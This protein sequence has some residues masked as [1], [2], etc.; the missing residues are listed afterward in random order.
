MNPNQI[1]NLLEKFEDKYKK[2]A[3]AASQKQYVYHLKPEKLIGTNLLSLGE[4]ENKHPEIYKKEVKKYSGRENHLTKKI[5]PL[6]CTWKDCIIFSSVN[7]QMIFDLQGLLGIKGWKE[8]EDIS[9][10]RFDINDLPSTM[11]L[12]DDDAE[13]YKKISPKSYRES[14]F[15][16]VSTARHFAECAEDNVYPLLFAGVKHVLVNEPIR[17]SLADT[18]HYK[19]RGK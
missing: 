3:E 6:G 14:E 4:L 5:E 16:P 13:S 10:M 15:I 7:P 12:Y 19:S 9:Y 8:A 2:L 18:F 1:I 11:C 17:I